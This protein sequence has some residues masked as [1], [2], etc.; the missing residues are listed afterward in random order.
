[1]I[2]V[3]GKE[4]DVDGE[5]IKELAEKFGTPFFLFSEAELEKNFKELEKS[6]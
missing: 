5:K 3:Q 4:L 6:N 1:M 2:D